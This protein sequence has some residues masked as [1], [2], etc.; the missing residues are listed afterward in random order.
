MDAA[1]ESSAEGPRTLW[2]S[3]TVLGL[4]A[5]AQAVIAVLSGAAALAGDTC[6]TPPPR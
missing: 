5:A 6:T 2:V 1:L 4:T 3:L